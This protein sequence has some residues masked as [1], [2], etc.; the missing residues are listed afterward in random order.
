MT[1]SESLPK[2]RKLKKSQ[3]RQ[4]QLLANPN[5]SKKV[6][7]DID[8]NSQIFR[9]T[10][11]VLDISVQSIAAALDDLV[12][13]RA[14]VKNTVDGVEHVDYNHYIAQF[15]QALNSMRTEL[16]TPAVSPI[17]AATDE[18]VHIFGGTGEPG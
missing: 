8:R 5:L 13:G 1:K 18:E 3:P 16:K 11:I 6:L 14:V 17:T 12:C 4:V 2:S 9:D 7:A 15:K 10:L